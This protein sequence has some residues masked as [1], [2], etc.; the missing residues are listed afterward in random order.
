M[1]ASPVI[2]YGHP[3]M[4][5]THP[6][7][8]T[9][10]NTTA[11]GTMLPLTASESSDG[12]RSAPIVLSP[13]ESPASLAEAS[14]AS[15]SAVAGG[16]VIFNPMQSMAGSHVISPTS[17]LSSGS[18]AMSPLSDAPARSPA[19]VMIGVNA[20]TGGVEQEAGT[21]RVRGRTAGG[22]SAAS[23]GGGGGGGKGGS[24]VAAVN[25]SDPHA[26]R[27]L[28]V[29]DVKSNRTLL[30]RAL[31]RRIPVTLGY[32]ETAEHGQ[33]A[34]DL[35]NAARDRG[36]PFH[37]VLTDKEMPVMDGDRLAAL[38]RAGG[39][40]GLIVGITGNALGSDQDAFRAAGCDV[41]LSKP[42]NMDALMSYFRRAGFHIPDA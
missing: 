36:V 22:T 19:S 28:I 9:G 16:S 27:V 21:K 11:V 1:R 33:A 3:P 4:P 23:A 12:R 42:V 26:I 24:S 18:I 29:D 40:T 25:P 20:A 41:V 34:V 17:V 5:S 13:S 15:G 37:A 30:Q 31:Q 39:F 14:S 35:F 8:N 10:T 6:A 7:T 32:Y 38:L 2:G